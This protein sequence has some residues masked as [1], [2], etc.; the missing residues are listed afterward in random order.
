MMDVSAWSDETG[1]TE[2]T[3]RSQWCPTSPKTVFFYTTNIYRPERSCG[4]VMFLHLSVI[5]FTGGC[6]ADTPLGR[7]APLQAD[8]PCWADTPTQS[9]GHCSGWYASYWYAFLFH[10]LVIRQRRSLC[11]PKRSDI[12]NC[13]NNGRIQSFFPVNNTTCK[14]RISLF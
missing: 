14:L 7:H 13:T 8:T 10:I 3:D 9:D 2:S 1:Y 4:K 11:S 6:L 5:L 12:N